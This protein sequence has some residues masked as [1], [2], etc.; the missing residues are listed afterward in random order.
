MGRS[1]HGAHGLAQPGRAALQLGDG[2]GVAATIAGATLGPGG[3]RTGDAG[4][5]ARV[6]LGMKTGQLGLTASA[7]LLP[8]AHPGHV[9]GLRGWMGLEIGRHERKRENFSDPIL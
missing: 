4:G 2:V 1:R 8:A 9:T 5:L 7:E 3:D 6:G